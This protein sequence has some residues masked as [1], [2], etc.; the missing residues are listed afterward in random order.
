MSQDAGVYVGIDVSKATLDCA[1]EEDGAVVMAQFAN[2]EASRG[3]LVSWVRARRAQVVV[4]EA[5]GGYE[6]ATVAALASA[7]LPVT[8]VNPRQVRDFA[9]ATGTLAKTDRIDAVV[10]AR[11]GRCIRPPVRA[12]KAEELSALEAL[13]ARRRQ[14]VD[15]LTAEQHRHAQAR[16]SIARQIDKHVHWLKR[17]IADVDQDLGGAIE[18]SSL[19]QR[20]F[21]VLTSVPGVGRVTGMSLVAHL[22]ELGQVNEK[23]ISALAGLCPY[24]RDSGKM[25]GRRTIFGGRAQVRAVLYMA[26]LVATRHNPAI[27]QFYQRLLAAG[28]PKKLALVACMH[29]LLLILNA[30]IKTD[31]PWRPRPVSA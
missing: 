13:L 29:K 22:P 15:M 16:G 17:Q 30:M 1:S 5:T 23:Q 11:F 9:K 2:G 28:K 20:K 7:G 14:L 26:A 6:A 21:D 10:L 4:V 12:P 24:N 31:T 19:M 18:R 25:R 8:V 27:R 3:E